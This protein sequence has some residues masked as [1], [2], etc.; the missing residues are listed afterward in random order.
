MT[1]IGIGTTYA[2]KKLSEKKRSRNMAEKEE[3]KKYSEERSR[4]RWSK[5]II[6]T[7]EEDFNHETTNSG[8]DSKREDYWNAAIL[9]DERKKKY[10]S[11]IFK[12]QDWWLTN[13]RNLEKNNGK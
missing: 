9:Q 10:A 11:T 7:E 6:R 8:R 3:S 12:L 4:W 2:V 5:K 1:K 13:C